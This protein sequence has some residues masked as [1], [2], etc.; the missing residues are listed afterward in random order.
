ML[1]KIEFENNLQYITDI[2]AT[3]TKLIQLA[4]EIFNNLPLNVQLI[5]ENN[6]SQRVTVS[7]ELDYQVFAQE[8]NLDTDNFKLIFINKHPEQVK[9]KLIESVTEFG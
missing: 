3:Y 1:L 6:K 9:E 7:N 5:Y 2:P 8:A 4:Y